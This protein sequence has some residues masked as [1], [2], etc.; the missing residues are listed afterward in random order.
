[1]ALIACPECG[2]SVSDTAPG[3]PHCGYILTPETVAAMHA[4]QE[5][6]KRDNRFAKFGYIGIALAVGYF[7]YS[8][9]QEKTPPASSVRQAAAQAQEQK[10]TT[11]RPDSFKMAQPLDPAFSEQLQRDFPKLLKACPG[12]NAYADDFTPATVSRPMQKNFEGGVE[13]KFTVAQRPVK[14]P[15]PLNTYSAGHSCYF[16]INKNGTVVSIAKDA[17]SSIC[18]GTRRNDKSGRNLELPLEKPSSVLP[19]T[20]EERQKEISKCFSSWDGSHRKLTDAVQNAMDDPKSF[21]HVETRYRDNGDRLL[22]FMTFR[23]KNKFGATVKNM[24]TAEASMDCSIV[25]LG[26]FY[27]D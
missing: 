2:R 23:G 18:E 21:E 20:K 27:T 11:P 22:L 7:V 1:M 3:C 25:K 16:D 4:A 12:L 9:N 14:L 8:L 6:S 13:I 15:S 10:N 19:K 5:K 24:V 26:E 17:C